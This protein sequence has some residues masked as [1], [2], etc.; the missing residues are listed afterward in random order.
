MIEPIARGG[1]NAVEDALLGRCSCTPCCTGRSAAPRGRLPWRRALLSSAGVLQQPALP[2]HPSAELLAPA[3][4]LLGA[5]ALQSPYLE[6]SF[7]SHP[8]ESGGEGRFHA[9]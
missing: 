4:L 9:A 1:G 8:S 7:E 6:R 3:P 2:H 5:S